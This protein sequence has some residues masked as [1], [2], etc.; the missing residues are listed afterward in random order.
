ME[1]GGKDPFQ[2]FR[3]SSKLG[4]GS[5]GVVWKIELKACPSNSGVAFAAKHIVIKPDTDTREVE[6]EIDILKGCKSPHIVSYYGVFRQESLLW[7]IMDYC[8]LGSVLDMMELTNS[9][10]TESAAA[11]ILRSTLLGLAYLHSRGVVHRDVK[12]GNILVTSEGEAKV[13]D[14]GVSEQLAN[15]NCDIAGSPLWMAPE[16]IQGRNYD[17]RCDIW[18][19]G[20]TAIEFVDGEPPLAQLSAFKAMRTIASNP[21]PTVED[22]ESASPEFLDFLTKALVKDQTGRWSIEKLLEHPFLLNVSVQPFKE[23][24]AEVLKMKANSNNSRAEDKYTLIPI[25]PQEPKQDESKRKKSDKKVSPLKAVRKRR[26]SSILTHKKK[27]RVR[28]REDGRKTD[29]SE[30]ESQETASHDGRGSIRSE[31]GEGSEYGTTII[32]REEEEGNAYG[33]T[34]IH[35]MGEREEE[36]GEESDAYGTTVIHRVNEED[37]E[38][39]AYGT[40]VIHLEGEEEGE[41]DAYSTTIIYNDEDEGDAFST[42]IIHTQPEARGT[43]RGESQRSEARGTLRKESDSQTEARGTLRREPQQSEARGALRGESQQPE[44]RGTLR[45]E[46]QQPEARGTL[47]REPQQS[48]AR[49]TLRKERDQDKIERLERENEA[50]RAE[51]QALKEDRGS[52]VTNLIEDWT[53]TCRTKVI[54]SVDFASRNPDLVRK[55]ALAAVALTIV[56]VGYFWLRQK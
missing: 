32:H 56:G 22:P 27:D 11:W 35:L 34:V 43:L 16:V 4:E 38:D 23:T 13:A 36:E 40:T 46:P 54:E 42:T 53:S 20:I 15:F 9:V 31:S 28:K 19:L 12:A 45:R 17:H 6:N 29:E 52:H 18:S 10:L 5:F 2:L 25:V 3:L 26:V 51:L 37:E 1:W 55:S 14:F 21:P 7:I 44:A 30:T 48:E 49:G 24:I 8:E 41:E 47:R 33:T 39:N 50:L